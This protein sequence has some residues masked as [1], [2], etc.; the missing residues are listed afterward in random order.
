MQS[1]GK[2]WIVLVNNEERMLT[3]FEIAQESNAPNELLEI[4]AERKAF[5]FFPTLSGYYEKSHEENWK[6]HLY[7]LEVIKG[8]Q[9]WYISK[10]ICGSF[11]L[12]NIADFTSFNRYQVTN[13]IEL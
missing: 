1:D 4:L 6:Q 3:N 9:T 8:N 7:P 13:G 10:L 2:P 5:P 11:I 12:E